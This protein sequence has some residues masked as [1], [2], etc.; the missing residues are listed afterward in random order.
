MIAYLV[1]KMSTFR[2]HTS[3]YSTHLFSDICISQRS[4]VA[5]FVGCL[6]ITLLQTFRKMCDGIWKIDQ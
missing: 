3:L 4:A 5:H 6:V 1:F 2:Q